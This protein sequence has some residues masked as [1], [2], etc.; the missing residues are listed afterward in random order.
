MALR[1]ALLLW[2]CAAPLVAGDLITLAKCPQEPEVIGKYYNNGS[3]CV[4]DRHELDRDTATPS[5]P[6]GFELRTGKCRQSGQ[7]SQTPQCPSGF[8]LS[9]KTCQSR[10]P[11]GYQ[12]KP[13]GKCIQP[14][15]TLSTQYMTCPD[16][17]H[18]VEQQCCLP[19]A[20][21]NNLV[22]C[23][24]ENAPGKFYYKRGRCERQQE[25]L[26]RDFTTVKKNNKC[27]E[28]KV[29]IRG[30]YC[31]D[32]C[33]DPYKARKGKCELRRCLLFPGRNSA[34]CPEGSYNIPSAIQ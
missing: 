22:E 16:G 7:S 1:L 26:A 25:A 33:P 18:R 32:P 24:V 12:K 23:Q 19:G 21:P 15:N 28:G 6:S 30:G 5:C 20:C 3:N 10:C 17:Q 9:G 13:N 4:R 29:L 14:K 27:P 31:Q 11:A 34:M 2:M 8:K